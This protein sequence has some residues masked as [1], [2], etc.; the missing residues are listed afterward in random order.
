MCEARSKQ[1][2]TKTGGLVDVRCEAAPGGPDPTLG[3]P[4]VNAVATR[5]G[6]VGNGWQAGAGL[7]GS[8]SK[9]AAKHGIAPWL[10]GSAATTANVLCLG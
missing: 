10:A 8:D 2:R 3:K 1:L 6:T 7:R 4:T 9:D 5:Q